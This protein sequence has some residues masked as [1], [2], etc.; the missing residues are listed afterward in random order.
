M[1]AEQVLMVIALSADVCA[2]VMAAAILYSARKAGGS[3]RTIVRRPIPVSTIGI[4][5]AALAAVFAIRFGV[6]RFWTSSV[7][8]ALLIAGFGLA[9]MLAAVVVTVLARITLGISWSSRPVIYAGHE[10]V[11]SG[12]Y[13]IIRHPIYT[14]YLAAFVGAGLVFGSAAVLIL[15]ITFVAPVLFTTARLEERLLCRQ[16]AEYPRYQAQSGMFLPRLRRQSAAGRA[17]AARRS[18]KK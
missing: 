15:A 12:I 13:S 17:W 18:E 9:L 1:T 2:V 5:V 3:R 16:F 10:L 14:S 7:S 6:G 4:P 11:T 8:L